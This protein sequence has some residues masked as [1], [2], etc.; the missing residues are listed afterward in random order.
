MLRKSKVLILVFSCILMAT[1]YLEAE[2]INL[3]APKNLLFTATHDIDENPYF[4]WAVRQR[5]NPEKFEKAKIEYLIERVRTSPYAFIRNGS[6]YTASQAA[7][8]L[9]EKY[10]VRKEKIK[11]AEQFIQDVASRSSVSGQPYMIK[12]VDGTS[13]P[14]E[15][16]FTNELDVLE[17]NLTETPSSPTSN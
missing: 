13:Y 6:E 2:L 10:R 12:L 5:S 16:I 11:T 17:L 7:K 3:H 14:T 8:H 15:E 9:G 4:D 1:P